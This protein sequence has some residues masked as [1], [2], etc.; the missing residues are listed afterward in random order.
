MNWV[1][2]ECPACKE[3][4]NDYTHPEAA[5]KPGTKLRCHCGALAEFDIKLV[6][7][8]ASD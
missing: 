2:W 6:K 1:S 4:G 7:E 8:A 5:I 3:Y